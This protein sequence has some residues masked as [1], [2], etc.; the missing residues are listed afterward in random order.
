MPDVPSE[1]LLWDHRSVTFVGIIGAG[2]GATLHAEAVRTTAGMQLAGV[3]ALSPVSV[4]AAT[5]AGELDCAAL[6]LAELA[7]ACDIAVV[8][9]PPAAHLQ[10]AAELTASRR[11]RAVLVE[12]PAGTTLESIDRLREALPSRRV[13]TGVNLL[14]APAVRQFLTALAAMDPHHLKLRLAVPQ[15]RRATGSAEDFGG[16]VLMDPAAGFW[17][18]LL[19]ALGEAVES[20]STV[21]IDLQGGLERAVEV[22]LQASNGRRAI[23][24]L[25]WGAR[26]AEA[27]VE[28]ADEQHV[29]RL[30]IWP[31]PALEIDGASAHGPASQQHPLAALGFLAQLDRLGRAAHQ[32]AAPWPDLSVGGAAVTVAVAAATSARRGGSEVQTAEVARN[33]SPFTILNTNGP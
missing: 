25:R 7:A 22:V 2:R 16:G 31:A 13:M 14:H 1:G 18:V 9:T 28:A 27:S 6:P 23:A 24:E 33:R 12:S 32:E 11:V 8:A 10:V 21:R 19:A 29:A 30:E 15:P 26:V 20:V 3:A 17:P 4:R 5:L